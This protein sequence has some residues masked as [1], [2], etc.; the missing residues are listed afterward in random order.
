ML[1]TMAAD[2][3]YR[4]H[5]LESIRSYML[6][7]VMVS[8]SDICPGADGIFGTCQDAKTRQVAP[9]KTDRH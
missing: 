3:M 9:A 5:H 8:I 7:R 1:H 6:T 2:M 4:P